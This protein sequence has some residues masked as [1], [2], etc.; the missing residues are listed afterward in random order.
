MSWFFSSDWHLGHSNIIKYC[1]RPFTSEPETE[2]M[3]MADR[4]TIPASDIR[5]S[6]ETTRRMTDTIIDSTNAVVSEN[7]TLVH[8][9]DF[10]FAPRDNFLD[11]LRAYRKRIVCKNIYLIWGNHDDTLRDLWYGRGRFSGSQAA[12]AVREV[13]SMFLGA[14]D[15]FLFNVNGQKIFCSHYPCRSWDCAHHAAWMLY[16][17]VHNLFKYED[18]GKLQPHDEN[19][20][21]KGFETI[22]G[23]HTGIADAGIVQE[24]LDLVASMKG[25]DLTVDVGVDNVHRAGLPWGTPWSMDDLHAYM[26]NKKVRWDERQRRLREEMPKASLKG[27]PNTAHPKF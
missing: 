16:G 26:G 21:R 7:D 15:Q 2:L 4:G 3:G 8:M 22:V 10:M 11:T 19:Y 13:R 1:R 9:G 23:N 5:I 20:L 18:N 25:I 6:S 27:D 14:Y 12:A 17:H 24:L